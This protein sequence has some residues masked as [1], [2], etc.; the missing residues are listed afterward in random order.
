MAQ[1]QQHLLTLAALAITFASA[2]RAADP[3]VPARRPVSVEKVKPQKIAEFPDFLSHICGSPGERHT[4]DR[5]YPS[6]GV[7]RDGEAPDSAWY[8]N[9]HARRRMSI[10]DLERGPGNSAPPASDGVWT[11][12]SAKTE[13]VT[14]G[15]QIQDRKGRRYLLKFDPPG[16]PELASGADVVVSKFFYALGYHVP[17]N[18]IVYFDR[19]RLTLDPKAASQKKIREED[20]DES[21]ARVTQDSRGRYRALASRLLEGEPV[22]PFRFHGTRADDP[23]DVIPHEHRR[24]LRGLYVFAAWLNHT[25]AKSGNTLD[26]VVREKGVT[27]IKHH[28]IDFGAALGSASHEAKSPRQGHEY[29]IDVKPALLQLVTFG[30]H[31]PK[32]A[33][34][35]HSPLP[36]VG[37]FE[38]EAFDPGRWKPNYPNPAFENRLPGDTRWAAKK[39]AAFR[40]AE[41]RAIV[42]TGQYSD[43]RAVDWIVETLI[44]RRNKLIKA[45][46]QDDAPA[47]ERNVSRR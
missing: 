8:H 5:T 20:V 35:K 9:R 38:A 29:H 10:E 15:F 17:E 28:L 33:R 26:M 23:N 22:G 13:G 3:I 18:Y 34:V 40:D 32:W 42:E 45:F 4:K 11:I 14:P 41:I 24:E 16:F 39:L 37:A 12:I 30:L 27:F 2:A 46:A 19:D 31:V 21:L 36:A 44:S 25:D 7:D 6:L 1:I 47:G 43:P